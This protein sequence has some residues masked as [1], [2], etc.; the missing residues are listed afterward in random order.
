MKPK[1]KPSSRGSISTHEMRFQFGRVLQ[2]AK[3]GRSLTLTCRNKPLA[4]IV[5]LK[6]RAEISPPD[7]VFRLHELAKPLGPLT[8]AEM[9]VAIYEGGRRCHKAPRKLPTLARLHSSA[10]AGRVGLRPRSGARKLAAEH[11]V[12]RT[13]E[14]DHAHFRKNKWT[15]RNSSKHR[16]SGWRVAWT[17]R[18][19]TSAR[20]A[21]RSS[22]AS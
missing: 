7:P 5:S 15:R 4:R 14:P 18:S 22:A 19:M 17:I 11:R 20:K 16:P 13:P 10:V 12:G 9:D 21:S 8:N 2:A 3:A 1:K 6:S